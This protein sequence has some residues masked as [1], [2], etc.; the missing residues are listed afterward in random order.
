MTETD[1]TRCEGMITKDECEKV[2]KIMK[3]N[4]SPGTDGLSIEFYVTFWEEIGDLLVES[5][6][7]AFSTNQL[8]EIF[9]YFLLFSKRVKDPI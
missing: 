7:E 6:N 5:Y 4:K 2:I 1:I 3:P 8:S 9:R